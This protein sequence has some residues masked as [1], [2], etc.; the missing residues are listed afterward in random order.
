L[1]IVGAARGKG[2]T[3]PGGNEKNWREWDSIGTSVCSGCVGNGPEEVSGK[4]DKM[5]TKN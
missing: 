5:P 4:E 3:L 1:E 2:E